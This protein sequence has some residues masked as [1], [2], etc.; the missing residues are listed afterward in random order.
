MKRIL[1]LLMPLV[2]QFAL[3][4]ITLVYYY[5]FIYGKI[6]RTML[7][8]D[9]FLIE[10]LAIYCISI[11]L[12][13]FIALARRRSRSHT[14]NKYSFQPLELILIPT[15]FLILS[16]VFVSP[17]SFIFLF[18]DLRENILLHLLIVSFVPYV[19]T[20]ARKAV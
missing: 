7:M 11:A 14:R 16:T 4:L 18:R 20:R 10:Y 8:L 19:I 5:F 9:P 3:F 13:W 15:L 17:I 2:I 12:V 1:D 6:E